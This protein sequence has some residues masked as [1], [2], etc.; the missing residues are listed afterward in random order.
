LNLPSEVVIRKPFDQKEFIDKV[1]MF[2]GQAG[3][4]PSAGGHP[5]SQASVDDDVLDAAL[6]LDR[7]DVTDSAVLT[8]ERNV[9]K[10]NLKSA[11]SEADIGFREVE[12][13]VDTTEMG[14]VESVVIQDAKHLQRKPSE[15]S[16]S[17]KLEILSDQYGISN[18][19]ALKRQT[20]DAHDYDWFIDEMQ[21]EGQSPQA[22]PAKPADV[23]KQKQPSP[24]LS[25]ASTSSMVDPVTPSPASPSLFQPGKKTGKPGDVEKFLSE[26]KEEVEKIHANEPDS[27][28]LKVDGAHPP[29]ESQK[30]S[31][32][33]TEM[34]VRED[35]LAHFTE[36]LCH[37]LAERLASKIAAKID[38][39]KL[40]SWIKNEILSHITK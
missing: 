13:P 30:R 21:K 37:E 32:R 14:K 5:L 34:S 38:G 6:G 7:I 29:T 18:P 10:K 39:A 9:Q 23:K 33:D 8:N 2:T 11:A 1:M 17:G 31:W 26:F 4:A 40:E 25:I 20:D 35:Q 28:N 16:A 19:G 27:V 15:L 12:Q 3:P 36:Q 24:E 22:P